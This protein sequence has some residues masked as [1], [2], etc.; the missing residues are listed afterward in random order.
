MAVLVFQGRDG[1]P[2]RFF[3]PMD[4]PVV[5]GRD[6]SCDLALTHPSISRRHA[7]IYHDEGGFRIEDNSTNGL[8]VNGAQVQRHRLADGDQLVLGGDAEHPVR[9]SAR[10]SRLELTMMQM[11]PAI[12]METLDDLTNLHRLIEVNKAI[13]TSLQLE[14]VFEL[15]LEGI[16]EI[17]SGMRAM[18]LLK[19]EDGEMEVA[20]EKNLEEVGASVQER[21]ISG[22]IVKRVVESGEPVLINDVADDPALQAQASILALDLRSIVAIPLNY[23]QSYLSR[24]ERKDPLMGVIYVDAQSARRRFS[25]EDLDMLLAF[26][27]Q[28]AICME[29]A[30]LHHDLQENYLA[31]VISLAEAVEIKDRYTRGH[32]ELVSRYAAAMAEE[33]SL[34][35]KEVEEIRRGGMLHDVGKIGIDEAILNKPDEL[36]DEELAIIKM[37]PVYGARILEPIPYMS[38]VRDIVL[39]H[40]ERMDGSGYPHGLPGDQITL[41]ARIVA[42]CDVFEGVTSER[43]YRQPMSPPQVVEFLQREA[44]PKL[45]PEC[46]EMFLRIYRASGFKKGEVGRRKG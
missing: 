20:Y 28:G 36:T 22:S 26:S 34:T 1:K 15:V 3:L 17:S 10:E 7:V 31:L 35:E 23:S 44:G 19:H 30:Q 33:L 27:F 21:G 29:N 9:F 41:G 40:H 12:A 11:Q 2:A 45:D 38:N 43:P 6:L 16:L 14:E 13:T 24:N 25:Q 32:S 8:F 18:I 5:L 37:H 39:H 42:V 46:V 4:R